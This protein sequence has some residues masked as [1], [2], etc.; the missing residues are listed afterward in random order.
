MKPF[1]G[2]AS[3]RGQ[4]LADQP[5]FYDELLFLGHQI[6]VKGRLSV[7]ENLHWLSRLQNHLPTITP[8][9]A[10]ERVGLGRFTDTPCNQLSAGQRRRVILAQLYLSQAP[11]WIL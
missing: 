2:T 8:A 1:K 6:P 7:A 4:P 10:L 11:L 5:G 9:A 3:W